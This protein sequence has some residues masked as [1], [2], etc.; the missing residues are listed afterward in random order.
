MD[1]RELDPEPTPHYDS[2]RDDILNEFYIPVLKKSKVYYRLAGF[3]SS[4]ALGI[5]ARGI[6]GL[7]Q[8]FE[9]PWES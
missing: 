3:F 9:D 4:T 5:A 6:K 1:F 7:M 2:D 8:L